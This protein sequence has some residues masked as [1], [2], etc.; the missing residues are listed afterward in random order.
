[1]AEAVEELKIRPI[2]KARYRHGAERALANVELV[3]EMARPYAARGISEFSRAMWQ[4]WDDTE[5]AGG[6]T[7]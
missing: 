1:M 4:N 6:G 3:L 2:L 5:F 7:A